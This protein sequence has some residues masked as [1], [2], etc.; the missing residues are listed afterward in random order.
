MKH[1]VLSQV[2]LD[3]PVSALSLS[4]AILME[5]LGEYG[6]TLEGL[7]NHVGFGATPY[8]HQ[9]TRLRQAYR[10][11]D[12][13]FKHLW[14]APDVAKHVQAP[15]LAGLC[16]DI[17]PALYR[18]LTDEITDDNVDE[19]F[20]TYFPGS[21]PEDMLRPARLRDW[22]GLSDQALKAFIGGGAQVED[23]RRGSQTNVSELLN[24]EGV[25]YQ[26]GV[27]SASP[28][29][30]YAYLFFLGGDR[31]QLSFSLKEAGAIEFILEEVH[32]L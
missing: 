19:Q 16:H 4:N 24:T 9:H 21:A 3:T 6:D 25:I 13:D 18:L 30:H 31:W 32:H 14:A 17:P 2:N 7:S 28:A 20:A 22:F 27:G 5:R 8:H 29:I 12:P 1:L 26:L 23:E 10:L 11:K 15:S